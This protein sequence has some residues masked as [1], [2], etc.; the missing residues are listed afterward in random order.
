MIYLE[1]VSINYTTDYKS[2]SRLRENRYNLNGRKDYLD[3]HCL[4]EYAKSIQYVFVLI[5]IKN[6]IQFRFRYDLI[7][8]VAASILLF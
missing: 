3:S 2:K 8:K 7:I 5:C 6:R 4:R 1:K